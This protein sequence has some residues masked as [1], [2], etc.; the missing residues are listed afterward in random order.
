MIAEIKGRLCS[1]SEENVLFNKIENWAEEYESKWP[2]NTPTNMQ[3]QRM[4]KTPGWTPT[5]CKPPPVDNCPDTPSLKSENGD[6]LYSTP[7]V[8]DSKIAVG[9][10]DAKTSSVRRKGNT[11]VKPSA[12]N[13]QPRLLVLSPKLTSATQ[14]SAPTSAHEPPGLLEGLSAPRRSTPSR[15]G[16]APRWD[17]RQQSGGDRSARKR[18]ASSR[19]NDEEQQHKRSRES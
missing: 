17:R 8:M 15:D 1:E 16:S 5:P 4:A 19:G 11:P 14:P 12:T 18:P 13:I 7:A 3:K 10:A 2:N 9:S 6:D